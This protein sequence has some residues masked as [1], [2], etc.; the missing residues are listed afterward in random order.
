[1]TK[2][3]D[4]EIHVLEI[5][6]KIG[7]DYYITVLSP[8]VCYCA[9]TDLNCTSKMFSLMKEQFSPFMSSLQNHFPIYEHKVKTINNDQMIYNWL[10]CAI[11]SG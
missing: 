7:I 9:F 5:K 3:S 2:Y 4:I 11:F 6:T 1:M 8:N 10:I